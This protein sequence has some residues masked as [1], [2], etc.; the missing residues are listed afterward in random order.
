MGLGWGPGGMWGFKLTALWGIPTGPLTVELLSEEREEDGE[1][2]GALSLLQHGVQLLFRDTDLP[3]GGGGGAEVDPGTQVS[4]RGLRLPSPPSQP[5]V[6]SQRQLWVGEGGERRRRRRTVAPQR[7]PRVSRGAHGWEGE[8]T[9]LGIGL[10]KVRLADDAITV[11]VD[12]A[13]GLEWVSQSPGGSTPPTRP[14]RGAVR[15]GWV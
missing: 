1:V 6:E 12:A 14:V 11:L 15:E 3:W 7:A 8:L 13:E 4:P 5:E 10:P 9:Q 2:D